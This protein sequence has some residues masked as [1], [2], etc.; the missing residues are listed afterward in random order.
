MAKISSEKKVKLIYSG[1]LLFF[2]I[3]FAV[4]AT[5]EI[6]RVLHLKEWVLITFNWLTI[7]GGAWMIADFFWVFFSMKRRAKNS[8]LDKALL[9]PLGIF[10]IVFDIICFAKWGFKTDSSYDF[11]LY[12]MTGAFYYVTAIYLFQAIYHYF[13]PVPMMLEAIKEEEESALAKKQEAEK[14]S[15]ENIENKEKDPE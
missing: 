3:V 12:M 9:V 4:I 8:L 5:L 1:E 15:E 11:R 14:A 7:F 13:Y 10:L 2:A 6:T